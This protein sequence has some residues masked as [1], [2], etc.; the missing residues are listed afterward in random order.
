MSNAIANSFALLNE[1]RQELNQ[2]KAANMRNISKSPSPKKLGLSSTTV[3][4]T[5]NIPGVNLFY[6]FFKKNF[7]FN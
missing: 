5:S 6:L 3:P 2:T 1:I 7:K 4:F